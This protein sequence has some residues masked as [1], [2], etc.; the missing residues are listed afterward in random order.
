M[1]WTEQ[2]NGADGHPWMSTV[3]VDRRRR[4]KASGPDAN[5][6][7]PSCLILSAAGTTTRAEA[8]ENIRNEEGDGM[9]W[10]EQPNGVG[11]Y[12]DVGVP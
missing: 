12:H 1:R 5:R 6:T 7:R 8:N 4:L 11:R 3:G 2:A 10:T 9:H